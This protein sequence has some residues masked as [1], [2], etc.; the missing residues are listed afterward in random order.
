MAEMYASWNPVARQIVNKPLGTFF[1]ECIRRYTRLNGQLQDN[2]LLEQWNKTGRLTNRQ[3]LRVVRQITAADEPGLNFDYV[4]LVGQC[5]QVIIAITLKYGAKW[6]SKIPAH[7]KTEYPQ[8]NLFINE[9][10]WEAAGIETRG[11]DVESTVLH[12]LGIEIVVRTNDTT[13]GNRHEG[14]SKTE[15]KARDRERHGRAPSGAS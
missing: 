13:R 15:T 9:I 10:L 11:L 5:H 2:T 3:L 14:E 6:G 12:A 1:Y 8:P 7:L 4:K